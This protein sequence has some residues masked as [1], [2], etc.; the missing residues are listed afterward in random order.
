MKGLS[1]AVTALILVIASVV[2]A[3]IVVGFA[4]GLFGTFGSQNAITNVGGAYAIVSNGGSSITIYVTL[5]NPGPN[6]VQIAGVSVNA[7][8]LTSVQINGQ[9]TWTV[10]VGTN[11]LTISGTPVSPLNV[12]P[13]ASIMVQ[14]TLANG[15]TVTVPAVVQA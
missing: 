8:P 15:Q 14:I 7:I 5:N 6:N 3:L 2:I 9:N 1:G 10:T 12:Q 11:V 4:F 13:G